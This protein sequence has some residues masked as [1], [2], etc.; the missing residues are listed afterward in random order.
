MSSNLEGKTQSQGVTFNWL[1]VGGGLGGIC[2]MAR[3]LELHHID[4]HNGKD[5]KISILW[6]DA[7]NFQAGDL[8]KR[9]GTVSSNTPVKNFTH[10][11]ARLES[12]GVYPFSLRTNHFSLNNTDENEPC[13][14]KIFTDQLLDVTNYW[15]ETYP[16]ILAIEGVVKKI[17]PVQSTKSS[18]YSFQIST[19][20]IQLEQFKSKSIIVAHGCDPKIPPRIG[21]LRTQNFMDKINVIPLSEALDPIRLSKWHTVL[22]PKNVLVF[23]NA[24]SGVLVLRN[25]ENLKTHADQQTNNQFDNQSVNIY[26]IIKHPI[27][28]PIEINIDSECGST[29]VELYDKTGIRGIALKWAQENL[30]PVNKSSIQ[31]LNLNDQ[32]DKI[33][34]LL[35]QSSDNT[36]VIFATGFKPRY[37]DI[38]T[39]FDYSQNVA[40][41]KPCH[42]NDENQ[43]TFNVQTGILAPNVYGLGLAFPETEY[44][45]NIYE[46]NVGLNEFLDYALKTINNL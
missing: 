37:L 9:Y 45:F 15:L 3:L 28:Y 2:G 29:S 26:N 8:R 5:S 18:L 41:I 13:L 40:S 42:H 21:C 19:K 39:E 25:L 43:F 30:Q 10:F 33:E 36:C 32:L 14:L 27:V 24:H 35:S 1:I 11:F 46:C 22:K 44:H 17:R 31:I 6:V 12:M 4:V 34:Q 23:G 16:F 38:H 7:D 20:H